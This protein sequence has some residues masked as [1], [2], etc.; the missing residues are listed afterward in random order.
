[1]KTR[2]WRA[3]GR[4]TGRYNDI[5]YIFKAVHRTSY[6]M[7]VPPAQ[8][9]STRSIHYSFDRNLSSRRS[10]LSPRGLAL[11]EAWS[12]TVAEAA[13]FGEV[14]AGPQQCCPSG[15]QPAVYPGRRALELLDRGTVEW[16]SMEGLVVAE[17]RLEL[18]LSVVCC[19]C[20]PFRGVRTVGEAL[21]SA[22]IMRP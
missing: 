18:A 3:G 20:S 6:S 19:L 8:V 11:I 1:M 5:G 13:R 16:E 2:R 15:P 21:R 9:C 4:S 10:T 14:R 22:S 12:P 7:H 17:R